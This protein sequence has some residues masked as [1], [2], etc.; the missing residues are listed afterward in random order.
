MSIFNGTL[1]NGCQDI[2]LKTT[3]VNPTV[4]QEEHFDGHQ[5][6]HHLGT[7]DASAKFRANP[8]GQNTSLAK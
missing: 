4:A 8:S 6:H 2:S 7:S 1:F 5:S 3:D